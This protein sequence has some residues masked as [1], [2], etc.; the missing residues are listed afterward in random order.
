MLREWF[1]CPCRGP[2]LPGRLCD[3]EGDAANAADAGGVAE[4]CFLLR[5]SGPQAKIPCAGSEGHPVLFPLFK[6][7]RNLCGNVVV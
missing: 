6:A 4:P 2:L 5:I 7:T 1:C 3:A